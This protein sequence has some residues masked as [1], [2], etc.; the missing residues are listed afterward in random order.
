MTSERSQ[1]VERRDMV[2]RDLDELTEQVESGEV[3]QDTADRLRSAYQAE[4]DQLDHALAGLPPEK[5]EP[6]Q[7]V[8]S[9]RPVTEVPEARTRS[10]RRVAAGAAILIGALTIAIFFAA[11]GTEPDPVET[12]SG[13]PGA[14]TVDPASVSNE[15]L[16]AVVEAVTEPEEPHFPPPPRQALGVQFESVTFGWS[17]GEPVL[18]AVDLHIRPG[19]TVGI[20]GPNGAGKTTTMRILTGFLP[21]TEGKAMVAG[22]DIVEQPLEV[23]KRIGYLPENCP[24]WPEMTVIDYLDYQAA[25]HSVDE[26]RRPAAVAGAIRRTALVDRATAPIHTLSRGYR[27]RVG[28]AQALLHE[29]DI[30]ILDEPTNGLDP[31][32][33]RH[34]RDLIR[35]L[36]ESAT[37]VVSTHILQEV[38]PVT[39]RVVIINEGG[40]IADGNVH[41]L[42]R[43]AMGSNRVYVGSR[44]DAASLESDLRGLSEVT[45][46]KILPAAGDS[47]A[48]CEVRGPFDAD[49][50]GAVARLARDRGWE[51]TQLHEATFSLEDTFIALTQRSASHKGVA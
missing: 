11:R 3:A 14:L 34:M 41:E 46:V 18:E 7:P 50:V 28:V 8:H 15:Q 24:L 6:H 20:V 45:E 26:P 51:L 13:S 27:Q 37:V 40:I 22:Y 47:E 44:R 4:L 48:R 1:L 16:E 2:R 29:P 9:A 36:A 35:E 10:P 42:A 23:K 49:L 31:T 5:P 39:D 43:D 19:E 38:S 21:P 32:Q 17:P 25:L 33:I 30:L 12:A